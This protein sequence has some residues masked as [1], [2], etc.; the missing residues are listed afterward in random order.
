MRKP[1]VSALIPVLLVAA[2]G[3]AP[4]EEAPAALSARG[5]GRQ[6]FYASQVRDYDAID[7]DTV[8]VTTTARRVFAL[9][10]LNS[11]PDINWSRQ[12]VL[13]RRGG[14]NFICQGQ[15]AD[16]LVPSVAGGFDRCPVLG[17]RQLSQA[18][19]KAWRASR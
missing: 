11:C 8:Y 16:L 5:D 19:V 3:C 10:L 4:R 14:S 15:D 1:A 17:I 9:D 18:E 2:A 13:Q 12:I 7:R 6:C